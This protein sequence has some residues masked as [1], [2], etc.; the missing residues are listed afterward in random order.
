MKKSLL[1]L[2]IFGISSSCVKLPPPTEDNTWLYGE[3]LDILRGYEWVYFKS[4]ES[5]DDLLNLIESYEYQ[6][7]KDEIIPPLYDFLR[8]HRK[9]IIVAQVPLREILEPEEIKEWEKTSSERLSD[10]YTCMFFRN[11]KIKNLIAFLSPHESPCYFEK[12]TG[13]T[14]F[15][16][17]NDYLVDEALYEKY[18][19]EL[20]R[21]LFSPEVRYKYPDGKWQRKEGAVFED[22]M[23]VEY[24]PG[25]ERLRNVCSG[26][27]VDVSGSVYFEAFYNCLK[28]FC[29]DNPKI[30]RIILDTYIPI[31]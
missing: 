15:F 30:S 9:K 28:G 19:G 26:Q 13:R 4:P 16:D 1:I 31:E 18:R 22:F 8:M 3:A 7:P 12:A 10:L 23:I 6:S 2:L 17:S 27:K 20:H 25:E 14:L 21:R 24:I 11:K 5:I 29:K